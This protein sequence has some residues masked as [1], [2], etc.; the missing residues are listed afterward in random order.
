MAG[1]IRPEQSVE[2]AEQSVESATVRSHVLL[3]LSNMEGPNGP[4]RS[5]EAAEQSV[6][7]ARHSSLFSGR[8]FLKNFWVSIF[9]GVHV[10]SP[11]RE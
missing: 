8:M 7:A 10:A 3:L 5:V 11:G 4:E 2:A 9:P 6:E 1:L